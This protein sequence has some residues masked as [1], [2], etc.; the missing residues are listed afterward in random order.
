MVSHSLMRFVSLLGGLGHLSVQRGLYAHGS[1]GCL[2]PCAGSRLRE[3][4]LTSAGWDSAQPF[5]LSGL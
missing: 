2:E 4:H 1:L 5:A 3:G